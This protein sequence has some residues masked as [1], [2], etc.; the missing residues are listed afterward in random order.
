MDEELF[1]YGNKAFFGACYKVE[2]V[3]IVFEEL[4]IVLLERGVGFNKL[5]DV[6]LQQSP[7]VFVKD[8]LHG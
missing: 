8:A 2:Q 6:A 3:V 5:L 4:L 7:H 1:Q